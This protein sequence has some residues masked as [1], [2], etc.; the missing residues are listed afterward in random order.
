MNKRLPKHEILEGLSFAHLVSEVWRELA[1]LPRTGWVR[2]G[3]KNPETVAEHTLS[4]KCLAKVLGDFSEEDR[5]ELTDMLEIH[6]WPE[7]IHG[8]EVILNEGDNDKYELLKRTK[9]EKEQNA[10]RSICEKIGG[11]GDTIFNLWIRFENSDDAVATFARQL[12]KYQAVEKALE[13]EK[14]QHIPLFREFFDY[15]KKYITHTV[16]IEQLERLE[17]EWKQLGEISL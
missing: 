8:D 10:L 13:Y 1:N 15:S 14:E 6:D 4:L 7:A 3:V 12:D 11:A 17:E 2:R 5:K 16:L 9:F